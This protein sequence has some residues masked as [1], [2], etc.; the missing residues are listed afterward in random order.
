MSKGPGKWERSI[1][2][3]LE[4]VPAFYLA[5]LLPTPHTRSHTVALNRAARNLCDA[6]KIAMSRWMTTGGGDRPG[7]L[8][9]YR[10]GYPEPS[11]RQV[12][13]LNVASVA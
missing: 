1:L 8:T 7:F 10:V 5:D 13:R 12:A 3:T 9:I 6:G 2:Q 11:P 4:R